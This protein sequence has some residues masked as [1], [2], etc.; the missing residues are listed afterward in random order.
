MGKFPAKRLFSFELFLTKFILGVTM[1]MLSI[2][3]FMAKIIKKFCIYLDKYTT[4][5]GL[6]P[7][8]EE[9]EMIKSPLKLVSKKF[10]TFL[11]PLNG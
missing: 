6:V 2:G 3:K 4:Y 7:T 9:R 8:R 5:I 10:A 1:H 11:A